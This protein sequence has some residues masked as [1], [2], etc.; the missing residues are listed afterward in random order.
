MFVASV[1]M[2]SD[3]Y[4][5]TPRHIIDGSMTTARTTDHDLS[6]GGFVRTDAIAKINPEYPTRP[7][8]INSISEKSA[9]TLKNVILL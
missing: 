7:Y 8:T 3:A 4:D 2:L 5:S 6:V 9:N 1:V